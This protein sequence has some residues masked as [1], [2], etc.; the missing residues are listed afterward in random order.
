MK[1]IEIKDPNEKSRIC[2]KIL[3]SLP[4]WFGIESAIVDYIKDVQN[5]ETWAVIES[6]VIGFVSLN[7]HNQK[8]TEIHVMGVLPAFHGQKI[9]SRLV[10]ASEE[11]LAKQGFR[12]LTVK[13]LSPYRPDENYDKIRQFYLRSGF[14]PIEE[15]KTLWGKHNPCLMMIKSLESK[16]EIIFI[17]HLMIGSAKPHVTS[18]FYEELFGFKKTEDDPG[19]KDGVVLTK[20]SVELLIIPFQPEKLPNPAHFAF[21]I[22]SKSK[23]KLILEKAIEMNLNPRTWPQKDSQPGTTEFK[24]GEFSYELFYVFDPSGVNLEI[25]VKV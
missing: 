1:I 20:D 5:M 13:T 8:T 4:K 7:K 14:T 23:F 10:E 24:R 15:F 9:G 3:R 22:R 25:M 16:D 21:E 19:A 2:E 12:F 11:S 18:K 17:N 6:D